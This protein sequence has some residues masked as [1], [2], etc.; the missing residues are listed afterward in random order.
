MPIT[1]T[2]ALLPVALLLACASASAAPETYTIDSSHTY[3]SF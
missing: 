1:R 2:T 3:P